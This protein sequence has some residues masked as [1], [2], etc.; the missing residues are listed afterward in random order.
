[1]LKKTDFLLLLFVILASLSFSKTMYL[2]LQKN[3][4][5]IEK[6]PF[7]WVCFSI[8]SFQ[9]PQSSVFTA[10]VTEHY[11]PPTTSFILP[12][13]PP[14][15]LRLSNGMTVTSRKEYGDISIGLSLKEFAWLDISEIRVVQMPWILENDSLIMT[16]DQWI[17][18][19]PQYLSFVGFQAIIDKTIEIAKKKVFPF[20]VLLKDEPLKIDVK[21]FCSNY[22]F[23][24][25][26][27]VTS[28]HPLASIRW[29]YG[30]TQYDTLFDLRIE[31]AGDYTVSYEVEDIYGQI[32]KGS[33]DFQIKEY[34]PPVQTNIIFDRCAVG[35]KVLF[36]QNVEG[37]WNIL[38]QSIHGSR[39]SWVFEFPGEYDIL[40]TA[41]KKLV[42]YRVMVR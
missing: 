34:T 10:K 42:R 41:A 9:I 38:D 20:R 26:E 8:D 31:N 6:Y 39:L 27:K 40:F 11:I 17:E 2:D 29:F 18:F 21:I 1:M 15:V 3:W 37:V 36:L 28:N 7:V 33:L 32:T 22:Y 13:T 35:A 25:I 5:I 14:H 12:F 24:I 19:L 30:E 16:D 23:P 4:G